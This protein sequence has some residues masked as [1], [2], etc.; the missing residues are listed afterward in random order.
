M[1]ASVRIFNTRT[2]VDACDYTP[3]HITQEFALEVT[4]VLNVHR[5]SAAYS[6]RGER[7]E[8]GMEVRGEGDYIPVATLSPPE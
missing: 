4:M 6:G 8:E 5:N 1:A 7:G 2:A 3:A